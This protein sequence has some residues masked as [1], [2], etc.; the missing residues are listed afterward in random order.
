MYVALGSGWYFS[1]V[2]IQNIS[3][4]FVLLDI[5]VKVFFQVILSSLAGVGFSVSSSSTCALCFFL[6]FT[7]YI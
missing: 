4:G 5:F 3:N 6:S 2:S 7:A 1:Q